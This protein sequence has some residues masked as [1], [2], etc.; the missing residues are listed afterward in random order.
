MSRQASRGRLFRKYVVVLLLLVGGVLALSSLV[1]LYFS[2]R[3]TR[4]ALT[5][6]EREKAMAAAAKIEQFIQEIERQVRGAVQDA[7]DDPVMARAQREEDYLRVLRNVP[8]VTDI[9][10][11]DDSG[12]EEVRVSRLEL[13]A[14]HSREDF[15]KAPIFLETRA[16]KSYLSPVLFRNESEP[17]LTIAVPAGEGGGGVTAAEV[18]LRAIWDVV[19]QIKVGATGY[20]YAVDGSGML[21]AHPDISMVLRK[22]DLSTLPQVRAARAGG[23]DPKADAE[24]AMVAP[25]L[26]GGQVL[27]A[28]AAIAPLGW[29]VII[30]QSLGEA[31]APLWPSIV[32]NAV[33]L[34]LGLGLSVLASVGLARRMVAPIRTLQ[35]GAAR[36]GAGDLGHRIEVRTGDE[37][38]ALG[39]EFNRTAGQLQASYAGLEQ[40]VEARTRELAAA[41]R[42][43]A[44]ALEELRA[45]GEIGQTISATL[46]LE[47]VLTSIV[48]HAVQLSGTDAGTI[49][50]FDEATATFH[51]RAA[52]HM[53]AD[54]IEALRAR[55][56][57]LGEGTVGRAALARGPSQIPDIEAEAAYEDRLR[58][59]QTRAG[60]RALLAV[61]L[62]REDRI[63]G[64]LVVRRRSPGEFPAA[65]IERL[66][67]FAAQSALA[68]QNARLFREIEAKGGELERLSRN[69][70]QLYRLSSTMQEPLSLRDELARVL[71]AAREVVG[72]D[73]I[74]V[75]AVTPD[76]ER[77]ARIALTGFETEEISA[78][79][80]VEIP[81]NEAGVMAL[82]YREGR[83][84]V[85]DPA[86]PVPP[87]LRLRPPYSRYRAM[88]SSSL[89]LVP[90]I[91]RGRTV[92]IIAADNK[93]SGAPFQP[94][95]VELLQSFA[96]HAAVAVENARLFQEIQE[97]SRQLE[98]ASQ[99]KS[100][101]LA[102]MSHELRTPLNAIIGLSEMLLE[103]ARAAEAADSIEPLDRILRAGNHLL[104]LINE[105]LDLS[106]IEA[107]KMELHL[108]EVAIR[109]LVEDVVATIRPL[110]EKNGNRLVVDCPPNGGAIRADGTRLRQALLN[111]LSNANKF[112]E[113]GTV[114]L[115]AAR[116]RRDGREWV[117]LAVTDTGIGMTPGQVAKL[118]EDFAE[119][120]AATRRKYGGTG[121]GLAISRR[122][123]RM[124]GGDITVASEPGSGSTFTI[125]L[126]A[127]VEEE[128]GP[129]PAE[130][131][132]ARSEAAEPPPGDRTIVI[133]DDDPTMR[134][135][136]ERFFAR[137]GYAPV[138]ATS[139]AEGL[140]RVR[141]LRPLA[142]ILDILLPDIDG[143][144]VLA[145]LKGDPELADIPVIVVTIVDDRTRGYAL[146]ATEYLVKP[147]DR[148]RLAKLLRR[149]CG[150]RSRQRVLVVE[151]DPIAR[152][153]IRQALE[154]DGWAVAEAANGRLALDRLAQ[155]SPDII[156]LDL[157][158]PEMDGFEF[159]A[160]VRQQDRWR[161]IPVLVVTAMDLTD[162]DRRRLN[163]GAARVLQ[164]GLYARDAL[165]GEIRDLLAARLAEPTR[166]GV[167]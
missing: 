66:Q 145:A 21:V 58:T 45:L 94:S 29:I 153:M 99:H 47:T 138:V 52:A 115:H 73:R 130:G 67:T 81:L 51:L 68:I 93:R 74:Y 19:S 98:I 119:V 152:E 86:H 103:D 4:L 27:A 33:V 135:L 53:D 118:F 22:R 11:L 154:G 34:V 125:R 76:G 116:E 23:P 2:Y 151:D 134:G 155:G 117:R 32:R 78:L 132:P 41:N 100:Q 158:M 65:V 17:F 133:I 24:A 38:E 7:F 5:R 28:H 101:F 109:P 63:L 75:W 110:A 40:K 42:D 18:N 39:Q 123:C 50:E 157:M 61:P 49:Y 126:P 167:G 131:Y 90:M 143:W 111:L 77:F 84:L 105:I 48:S 156:V 54:L 20:A 160:E 1:Q 121:L 162:E 12:R 8:A 43:L 102:N 15:S 159:L 139:G 150:E 30:E 88:R 141:E 80:G 31:F 96:A 64:G 6:I 10:H 161:G 163:G 147:I 95:T 87:D 136:M 9:R 104:N 62:L 107:G 108:E 13:D 82:A 129:A 89:V 37:L 59:M 164:K 137:E 69:V 83:P 124:M 55:P 3:E 148:D 91:A 71:D 70:Q 26:D 106:K 113:R 142:V 122:F 14:M 146:G 128:M 112:T 79:E 44:G 72:I 144:T 127:A 114:T 35:E 149:L 120:D 165:L 92:G 97:K 46:D 56:V 25:G 16:G 36:I 140:R 85:F 166:G 60:F 57:A